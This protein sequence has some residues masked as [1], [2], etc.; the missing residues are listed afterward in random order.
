ML[1]K[2]LV[3]SPNE[4]YENAS[5]ASKP[6][7]AAAGSKV[8]CQCFHTGTDWKVTAGAPLL[9]DGVTPTAAE[10]HPREQ[11]DTPRPW[12]ISHGIPET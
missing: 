6:F 8:L 2:V 7:S 10:Q 12:H 5:D 4:M 3:A 11:E 9:V 1:G